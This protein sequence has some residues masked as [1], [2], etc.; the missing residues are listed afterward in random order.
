[1]SVVQHIMKQ[2][3]KSVFPNV[4]ITRISIVWQSFCFEA[5]AST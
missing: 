1:M 2:D 5:T 3:K 4:C